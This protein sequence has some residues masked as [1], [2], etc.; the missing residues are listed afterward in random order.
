MTVMSSFLGKI[1][2]VACRVIITG[3][4][5]TLTCLLPFPFL[6]CSYFHCKYSHIYFHRPGLDGNESLTIDA[7]SCV[8]YFHS[9][10][11]QCEWGYKF[12]ATAYCRSVEEPPSLPPLLQ[13][14]LL[15]SLKLAGLRAFNNLLKDNSKDIVSSCI[16]IMPSLILSSNH[17]IPKIG[18]T[19]SIMKP[20]VI[21]SPHPYPNSQDIYQ[22]VSIKGAKTLLVSFDEMS[23]M[24][25]G[26]D[27]VRFYCDDTHTG[28]A[29][30]L[31]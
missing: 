11:S 23:A 22:T 13:L 9:D 14:S 29:S 17:L 28:T 18:A 27:Y 2:T 12:K 5:H 26:C 15:S 1:L 19:T 4:A 25:N 3:T 21:E 30:R 16:P 6:R 7:E 20:L 10:S 24:E 8:L 31:F